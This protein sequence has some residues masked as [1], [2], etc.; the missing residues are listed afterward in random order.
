[1]DTFLI[2]FSNTPQ[3]FSISIGDR[4]YNIIIKYNFALDGCWLIDI[5]DDLTGVALICS[6]PLITGADLL[7]QY[8]YVGL[9]AKLIVYTDGD[10]TAIP[11]IDN[12]GIDSN[13]YYQATA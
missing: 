11:T 6:I 12:L 3:D 4:D 1:M 9:K 10:I 13:V 5:Y 8:A 7:E 2:P